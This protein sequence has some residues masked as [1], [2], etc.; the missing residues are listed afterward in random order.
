MHSDGPDPTDPIYRTAASALLTKMREVCDKER[1][2]CGEF[3]ETWPSELRMFPAGAD[4]AEG[5]LYMP[6][7]VPGVYI[8]QASAGINEDGETETHILGMAPISAD[9]LD[10][11]LDYHK[12]ASQYVF[13]CTCGHSIPKVISF[14]LFMDAE[15]AE[16]IDADELLMDQEDNLDPTRPMMSEDIR[17]QEMLHPDEI[18]YVCPAC[19]FKPN[20]RY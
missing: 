6:R 1:E 3:P 5:V 14:P 18:D 17:I 4:T 13:T 2:R 9:L 11:G 12:R 15:D 16:D 7:A 20:K 19:G 8:F 10:I